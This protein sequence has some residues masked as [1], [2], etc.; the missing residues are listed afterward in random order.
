MS[1]TLAVSRGN[2][3]ETMSWESILCAQ[4]TIMW[5][6]PVLHGH[7]NVRG[8]QVIV[9]DAAA[10]HVTDAGA[11]VL[12]DNLDRAS[13]HP[14]LIANGNGNSMGNSKAR[15]SQRGKSA[16]CQSPPAALRRASPHR[17]EPGSYQRRRFHTIP[18][19]HKC[20]ASRV[21]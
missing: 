13:A 20:L 10:V 21:R 2:A 11:D 6:L 3:E 4:D 12:R 14:P 17:S 8:L 16:P 5:V 15:Y 1:M 18:C 7:E 19:G 9:N